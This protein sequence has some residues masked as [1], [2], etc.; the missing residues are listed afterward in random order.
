MCCASFPRR[1]VHRVWTCGAL[2]LLLSDILGNVGILHAMRPNSCCTAG[3]RRERIEVEYVSRSGRRCG[4]DRCRCRR[5][6]LRG[7]RRHRRVGHQQR[8][9]RRF[10]STLARTLFFEG[11]VALV[12]ALEEPRTGAPDAFLWALPRL[13]RASYRTRVVEVTGRRRRPGHKDRRFGRFGLRVHAC[14]NA[15]LTLAERRK[16]RYFPLG[17]RGFWR[18][19]S[20]RAHMSRGLLC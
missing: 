12:L 7:Q 1:G 11:R 17:S 8:R 15:L 16:A 6:D 19:S 14:R 9:R 18:R 3:H 4:R 10:R 20:P 5:Q 2:P 13:A